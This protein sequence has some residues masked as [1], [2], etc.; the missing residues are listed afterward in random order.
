MINFM[1]QAQPVPFTNGS[2]GILEHMISDCLSEHIKIESGDYLF[3]ISSYRK[4]E[5]LIRKIN[6]TNGEISVT[7]VLYPSI[8]E[9][10]LDINNSNDSFQP[11]GMHYFLFP[12]NSFIKNNCLYLSIFRNYSQV[13]LPA[14]II[15]MDLDLNIL[16]HNKKEFQ[17]EFSFEGN[18]VSICNNH[19]IYFIN[20]L[21]EIGEKGKLLFYTPYRAVEYDDQYIYLTGGG[22]DLYSNDI[23]IH[24]KKYD[25]DLN[26][27]Y[28]TTIDLQ[29]FLYTPQTYLSDDTYNWIIPFIYFPGI[30]NDSGSQNEIIGDY[31]FSFTT[32]DTLD[33]E[34]PAALYTVFKLD[35][36]PDFQ[37]IMTGNYFRIAKEGTFFPVVKKPEFIMENE[38]QYTFIPIKFLAFNQNIQEPD[39]EH[40]IEEIFCFEN[41]QLI[42]KILVESQQFN[43]FHQIFKLDGNLFYEFPKTNISNSTIFN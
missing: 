4:M 9:P 28:E 25:F 7:K 18:T 22:I 6:K 26:E 31:F 39:L 1:K 35:Q 5:I 34:D 40:S 3:Y 21:A 43:F 15:K 16:T 32:S 36:L 23:V 24:T 10:G 11:D 19:L 8:L 42:G 37:T 33:Q 13:V 41:D 2:A 14:L 27:I 29:D 20:G 17:A 38:K 30:F 12:G